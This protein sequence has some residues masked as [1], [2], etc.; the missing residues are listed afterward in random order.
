MGQ[1]LKCAEMDK[2]IQQNTA[3]NIKVITT[4]KICPLIDE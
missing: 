3:N 1:Y 2:V 4:S